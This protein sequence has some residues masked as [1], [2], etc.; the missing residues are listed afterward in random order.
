[1]P[2]IK[3]TNNY[4]PDAMFAGAASFPFQYGGFVNK[5]NNT[6]QRCLVRFNKVHKLSQ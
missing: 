1:M 6:V 5:A 2:T 3:N 4:M